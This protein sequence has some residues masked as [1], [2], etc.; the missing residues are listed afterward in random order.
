MVGY[1]Q[2]S[3]SPVKPG[4]F[5]LTGRACGLLGALTTDSGPS[6]APGGGALSVSP[7]DGHHHAWAV[8]GPGSQISSAAVFIVK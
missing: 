3:Q 7:M 1:G 2:D 4:P 8:C 6:G 5:P